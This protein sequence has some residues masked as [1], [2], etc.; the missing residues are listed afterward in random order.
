MLAARAR[1]GVSGNADA[2]ET[3]LCAI[4]I[5]P[6][7]S[8]AAAAKVVPPTRIDCSRLRKLTAEMQRLFSGYYIRTTRGAVLRLNA[9]LRRLATGITRS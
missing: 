6:S 7:R 8:L 3:A 5:Y 1:R 2:C 9:G 4:Q